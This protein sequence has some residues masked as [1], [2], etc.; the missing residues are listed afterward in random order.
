IALGASACGLILG[1]PEATR[2]DSVGQEAGKMDTGPMG[3][4]STDT[5]TGQDGTMQDT[6]TMETGTDG[7][8]MPVKLTTG[9]RPWGLAIDDMYVFWSETTHYAID[10]C[11]KDGS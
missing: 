2:D 10:R 7:G 8:V 3:D 5:G 1:I 6:G 11:N 9:N 4:G